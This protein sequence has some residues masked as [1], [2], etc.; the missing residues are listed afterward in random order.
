MQAVPI[1]LVGVL[2]LAMIVGMALGIS[3]ATRA[4][5]RE[6]AVL[7]AL[8]CVGRQLRD[9]VRWHAACRCRDRARGRPPGGHGPRTDSPT[10]AS[11]MASGS[12]RSRWYPLGW[13]AIIAVATVAIGL[14]A[15]AHPA[16]VAVRSATAD[17]LRPE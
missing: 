4:R 17:L 11:P 3:A 9:S 16:R 7:R 2:A 6:M 10:G 1:A 15:A 13:T 5:R 14:L 8:G 12:S